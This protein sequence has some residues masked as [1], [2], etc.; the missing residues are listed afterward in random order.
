MSKLTIPFGDLKR[1][2]DAL[3]PEL[4]AAVTRVFDSGWYI[5]GQE[6]SAFEAEFAAYC[7]V[8]HC[9]GVA[10][11]AEALYL[12]LAALGIGPGDEVITVANACMYQ[13]S[14]IV[15]TG[16][17]PVLVEIEPTTHNMQPVTIEAAITARTKAI[18]PVHLYGRLADMQ[19]ICAIAARHGVPVVED[20][21]QAHG[22]SATDAEGRE[23]RAGAW[24][25]LA[26][27]SFY[28]SKNLGA[29][30]DAGAITTNDGA[31]AAKLRQ[32]RFY[33]W[34]QKYVTELA[35]GRN[36]RL[37]E[38]QAALLRVKLRYLEAGNEARRE[39]AA[40]Y[41]ELLAGLPLELPPPDEG[42]VYHL[43][44]VGCENRDG[45][46]QHL[47][48]LGIGCDI[49]YPLP[50]HLHPAYASLGYAPGAL[51]ETERQAGRILSLPIYP[52]LSRNE[53]EV[54]AAAVR[55]FF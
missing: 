29:L 14:A 53:V 8:A 11:G 23:R 47:L 28:P 38:L 32:L 34:G 22:A 45:L 15:Q 4:D 21:A 16:A 6:V 7:G 19:Q 39:R 26:C 20:A 25:Q 51:P 5:L 24:G 41:Q 27:F 52:E 46:R 55:S 3:R 43:Y 12:A 49:H 10:S 40:W 31:L 44:V 18:L 50:A 30:G 17:T 54:V 13:V 33:G 36:S 37:D 9:V 48:D 2:H 35:G 42:H 1:Q